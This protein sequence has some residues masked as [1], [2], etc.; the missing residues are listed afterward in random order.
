MMGWG[1]RS[2]TCR[3]SMRLRD[4]RKLVGTSGSTNSRMSAPAEKARS[5]A[6]VTRTTRTSSSLASR[7]KTSSSSSRIVLF[8]AL[9][10]SGRSRVTVATCVGGGESDGRV[11]H[12]DSGSRGGLPPTTLRRRSS[13]ISASVYPASRRMASVCWPRVGGGPA[14]S[15]CVS[16]KRSGW[17]M[18]VRG[19]RSGDRTGPPS[20]G[21]RTAGSLHEVMNGLGARG[22]NVVLGQDA[23]P[24]RAGP[25]GEGLFELR[26]QLVAVVPTREPGAEAWVVG[27]LGMPDGLAE[28]APEGLVA[29][30]EKNHSPSCAW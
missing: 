9:W 16:E 27:H 7:V 25:G 2:M 13:A 20:C 12:G 11:G 17:P 6:P 23:Q 4:S 5:P 29:D 30:G 21:A 22:R 24:L 3:K 19:P 15:A 8:I 18:R 1:Q 26:H 10:T 14:S 28:L